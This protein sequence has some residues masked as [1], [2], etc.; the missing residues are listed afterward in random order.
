MRPLVT[1][2]TM[3]LPSPDIAMQFQRRELSRTVQ[4]KDGHSFRRGD[5][6]AAMESHLLPS[7]ISRSE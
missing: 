3:T 7:L 5:G 1:V 4:F 2:A 6:T